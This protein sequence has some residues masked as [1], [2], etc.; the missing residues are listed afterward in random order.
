[1]PHRTV[2]S[3]RLLAASTASLLLGG[4]LTGETTPASDGFSNSQ[5]ASQNQPPQISG[6][7]GS[8]VVIGDLYAFAPSAT[9]PDGDPL[10]FSITGAPRW[11][12][13]DTATGRLSGAPT[14]ADVGVYEAIVISVSDGSLTAS[15]DAF[16]IE[17][18]QVALGSMTLNWSAP[19]ENQDGTV[20]TDLAGYRIYYGTAAGDYTHSV[21]IDNPSITTTLIENLVP[22]TY[23]VVATAVNAAGVESTYSNVATK[24]VDPS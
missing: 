17:V 11:A 19:I 18:S 15:L 4:C 5:T 6:S 8:A 10:T 14:L 9:D 13:F 21:A 3:S 16:S 7:A 12:S 23:Y 2:T 22:A 24:T 1:M 20:L